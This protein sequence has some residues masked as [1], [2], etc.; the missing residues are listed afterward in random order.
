MQELQIFNNPDFGEIRTLTINDEPWF[1]GKDVAEILG[2]TNPNEA[3]QDHIDAED[4]LN[5]KTLSSFELK[6]GQRGGWLINESGLYSLILSS[7][8]ESAKRFKRWVTAEV[9][10]AIRKTGKYDAKKQTKSKSKPLSSVNHA[11][12]I[13]GRAY[14]SAGIDP[15]YKVLALTDLYRAEGLALPTPPMPVEKTYDFTE[16]AKELGIMSVSGKPHSQA[17]GAIVSTLNVPDNLIVHAPFDRN[18]HGGDYDRYKEPVLEQVRAW[19]NVRNYHTPIQT[20]NGKNY[21]VS[22]QF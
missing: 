19:L 3:I 13:M 1:V 21:K 5:S 11:A 17:V 10:P 20:G 8:L 16:M 18:G 22:Y 12:E 9:L 2:Y 4:K 7:K 14:D 6:L 15:C